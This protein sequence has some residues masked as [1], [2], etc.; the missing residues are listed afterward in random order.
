MYY[1]L[2]YHWYPKLTFSFVINCLT[3]NSIDID[4]RVQLL[5]S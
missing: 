4:H 3:S 1:L 5:L 2:E